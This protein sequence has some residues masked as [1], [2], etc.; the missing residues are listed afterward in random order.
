MTNQ[1][2]FDL[3][4]LGVSSEEMIRIIASAPSVTFDLRPGSM[5]NL[6]KAGV[7]DDVIK[8]MAAKQDGLIQR[9]AQTSN[10]QTPIPVRQKLTSSVVTS[11]RPRVFVSQSNDSWSYTAGRHWGQGSTHPQTVEVIKTFGESCPNVVITNDQ[12]KADYTVSFERE[13]NKLVRRH[14]K[15]AAFDRNGD[16]VFSK[17]TRELGNAVRGFCGTLR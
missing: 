5:E 9:F 8:A 14:N 2:I 1:R 13:S 12:S 15:F 6:T 11:D 7:S 16:M 3:A 17:S 10:L 4:A